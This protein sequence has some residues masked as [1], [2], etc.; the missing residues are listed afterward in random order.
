MIVC[1]LVD[2]FN[3]EAFSRN[4]MILKEIKLSISVDWDTESNKLVIITREN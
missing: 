4:S 1:E 3:W 2:C